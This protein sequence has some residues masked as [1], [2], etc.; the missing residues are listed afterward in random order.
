MPEQKPL[1]AWYLKPRHHS[2]SFERSG[3]RAASQHRHRAAHAARTAHAQ[4]SEIRNAMSQRIGAPS[5]PELARRALL[6]HRWAQVRSCRFRAICGPAACLL[7]SRCASW[8]P[9]Y[10]PHCV[11]KSAKAAVLSTA[12]APSKLHNCIKTLPSMAGRAPPTHTSGAAPPP[13]CPHLATA[14][15]MRLAAHTMQA[16]GMTIQMP[17]MITK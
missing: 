8:P 3:R 4:R 5:R 16:K 14:A 15:L 17:L 2:R 7:H 11:G 6:C 1:F 9:A 13:S 12:G 10:H